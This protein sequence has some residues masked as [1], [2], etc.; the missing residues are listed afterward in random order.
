MARAHVED[1]HYRDVP[2]AE[3]A[4]GPFAGAPWRVL[5][6]DEETGAL[7]AL[8]ELPAGYAVD[9]RLDRGYELLVLDGG[10]TLDGEAVGAGRY[11]YVPTGESAR[12]EAAG[13]TRAL[14]VIGAPGAGGGER[15]VVDPESMQWMVRVTEARTDTG[16]TEPILHV[17]KILR[18]DPVSGDVS[19]FSA[20]PAGM[21]QVTAEWHDPADE[22]FMLRGD[23]IVLG[24]DGEP[25]EMVVGTYNWR[26]ENARHLPKYTHTGNLRFFRATGGGFD[27]TVTV[28]YV[29]EPRWPQLLAAYQARF[30]FFG[31]QAS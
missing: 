18:R 28:T 8:A 24:P 17:V 16:F 7:T 10:L 5:S 9:Q 20:L 26:P 15:I 19:G 2:L 30:P 1:L 21:G 11:A 12:V 25:A 6:R 29:D 4:D 23:M 22:G 27:G 3:A 13:P 31:E 14:I